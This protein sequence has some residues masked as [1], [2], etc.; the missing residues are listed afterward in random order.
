MRRLC[1]VKQEALFGQ[2][3]VCIR[4][5]VGLRQLPRDLLVRFCLGV[6]RIDYPLRQQCAA[7]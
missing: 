6:L 5:S 7:E 3:V 2:V 4:F 1:Y